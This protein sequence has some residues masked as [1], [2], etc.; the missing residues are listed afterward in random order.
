MST[1][2]LIQFKTFTEAFDFLKLMYLQNRVG[3]SLS[4]SLSLVGNVLFR[5]DYKTLTAS[6]G[7]KGIVKLRPELSQNFN[8][9]ST[10]TCLSLKHP[11]P[12][13]TQRPRL[14]DLLL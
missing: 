11:F 6:F 10:L 12:T 9:P 1:F 4:L 5:F 3:I 14:P 13:S 2:Y 7:F 8:S